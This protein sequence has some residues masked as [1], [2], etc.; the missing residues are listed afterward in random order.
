MSE[1]KQKQIDMLQGSIVDKLLWFAI[2]LALTGMLQQL[3]NAADVAV[4]GQ[5]AGKDAMAAVGS[6]SAIISLLVNGFAGIALGANVVIS[7]FTGQKNGAGIQ[8]CVHS[9]VLFS[10]LGGLAVLVPGELLAPAL[11]RVMSVPDTVFPMALAYLRIYLLGMPVIFLYNF[12]AAIFR[13]QGDTRTPLICLVISGV[14]NVILNLF[15]V[16]VVGMTADGV[17]TAT[18]ISNLVS[19]SLL[20]VLLCRRKDDIRI[21]LKQIRFYPR[22][23]KET[24]QIGLPAGLQS[25]VFSLS[26]ICIQSA[27]NSLGSDVM[28][29]SSAAFNIEV[30]VN[31]L[32]NAFG[33]AATTF[34]GQNYGASNLSRCRKITR[35]SLILDLCITA[36]VSLLTVVFGKPL[37]AIFNGDAVIAR[38]G[39]V[40]LRFIVSAE[41]INAVMEVISGSL[42]GYGY[43]LVPA[44]LTFAGVCGTRIFWVYVIFRKAPTFFTLMMVY[45][46]SWVIT[47]AALALAY[48]LF[49]RKQAARFS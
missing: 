29:A 17:A 43:S 46:V 42:R 15:F 24:V 16:C 27:I 26:N 31:Y 13:S 11:L 2:P 33:Q 39:M 4:V 3:F 10:L 35:I 1:G 19:A 45:P 30:L 14:L 8:R 36:V 32:I 18:V 47:A 22:E 49:I 34:V 23:L 38:I 41:V 7:K 6:N 9:A 20:F 44:V 37:L 21:R 12:E 25:M 5:F 28:A 48:I 40:R